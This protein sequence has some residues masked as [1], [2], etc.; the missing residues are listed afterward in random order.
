MRIG[1]NL[2]LVIWSTHPANIPDVNTTANSVFYGAMPPI[3]TT[4]N[5]FNA[6][7]PEENDR[8]F[9]H[10]SEILFFVVIIPNF[11]YEMS[12]IC[13][14]DGLTDNMPALDLIETII[15]SLAP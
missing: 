11:L 8:H 13:V 14:L 4:A 10:E 2:L 12:L 15:Y 7:T 5:I 9:A 1:Y 3:H 6:L